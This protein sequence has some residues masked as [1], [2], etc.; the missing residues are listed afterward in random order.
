MVKVGKR[1]RVSLKPRTQAYRY[2]WEDT[3][4]GINPKCLLQYMKDK[5]F[6]VL[7][8]N[9]IGV[10][11]I[12]NDGIPNNDEP[13]KWNDSILVITDKG[14]TLLEA[15]ST[16][17]PGYYYTDNPLNPDGC[18]RLKFGQYR[19][20]YE[21]GYHNYNPQH[22]ALV[23]VGEVTV[24][25]DKNRDMSRLGDF[26]YTGYFG[27]NIHS[28]LGLFNL[29]SIGMWSA[30]CQVIRSWGL[31]L[32]MLALMKGSRADGLFNYTLIDGSDLQRFC[33]SVREPL[34]V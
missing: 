7:A 34:A 5:Q 26:E 33:K 10:E 18:A 4:V 9:L 17:E 14:Q 16:T 30:G 25:R 28:T 32:N 15:N 11:G 1:T 12:A 22:P 23:Q 2:F 20:A 27:I 3:G 31:H 21:F 24:C 13:D 19:K 8:V 29:G 6:E